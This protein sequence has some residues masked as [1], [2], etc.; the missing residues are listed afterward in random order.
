R[1]SALPQRH[2]TDL[3]RGVEMDLSRRRYGTFHEL[4]E[5]CYL[6]ASTV[7]LLCIEIFG[8]R[9]P[10]AVDYARDLGIAFQLTNILRDV[11]EDG[12]RGRIYLPLEDLR[13]FGC[14]EE[15]LL[16]GRDSAPGG[17]VVGVGVRAGPGLL[18]R[19][20]GLRDP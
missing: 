4:E 7:G 2:F 6:V 9:H 11:R 14:D 15:E 10:A 12:A 1:R 19:A 3:I 16:A 17:A 20:R 8:R 5:Y 13:S 18:P